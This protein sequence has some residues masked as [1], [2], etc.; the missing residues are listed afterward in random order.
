MGRWL[1]LLLCTL[2]I[3]WGSRAGALEPQNV[4]APLQ[5]WV[6]WVLAEA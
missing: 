6:T 3:V 5:P 4:P 1:S 2:G